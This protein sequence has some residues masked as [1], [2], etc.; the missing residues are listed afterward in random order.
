MELSVECVESGVPELVF[1][2]EIYYTRFLRWVLL[3]D[4]EMETSV[5]RMD[6]VSTR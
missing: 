2:C 3:E 5:L 1:T 6:D 4:G